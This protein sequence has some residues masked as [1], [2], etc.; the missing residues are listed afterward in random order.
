MNPVPGWMT[1]A[2]LQAIDTICAQ[3][4]LGAH[5][6][7]I[8]SFLGRSS[9]QWAARL[10]TSRIVCVD[11]WQGVPTDYVERWYLEQCWGDHTLLHMNLPMFPQFLHNT[12]HF[13]NIVPVRMTSQEFTWV[14]PISPHVIFLDGDHTDVGVKADLDACLTRWCAQPHTIIC[15]HDYNPNFHNSVYR[16]VTAFAALHGFQI[17]HHETSTVFELRKHA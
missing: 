13:M 16:Q 15:G 8:G 4:P 5:V 2:D 17:V 11:A 14:W 1:D 3:V 7:E 10:P 6:L 12:R 9:I